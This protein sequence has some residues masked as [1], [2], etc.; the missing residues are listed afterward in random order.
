MTNTLTNNNKMNTDN[1]PKSDN[2]SEETSAKLLRLHI[3]DASRPT[4]QSTGTEPGYKRG[5]DGTVRSLLL[6]LLIFAA[7]AVIIW[8]TK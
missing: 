6:A 7:T 4:R 5:D 8:L 1:T 3:E 2:I